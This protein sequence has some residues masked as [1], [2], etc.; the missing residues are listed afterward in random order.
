MPIEIRAWD[1]RN[2]TDDEVA[3]FNKCSNQMRAERLPDDPPTPLEE[4]LQGLK[5]FPDYIQM[6]LWTAWS[7]EETEM[8]AYGLAQYSLEDNLHMA[9]FA[10]SVLPEFRRQ[11]LGMEFLSRIA[12][13]AKEQNRRLLITD[14]TTRVPAGEAFMQRIGAERGLE[15]HTNQLTIADLDRNLVRQWQERAKERATQPA[16]L[17]RSRC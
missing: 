7:P 1:Y 17:R 3:A 12:S 13:V 14:T 16:T 15:T 6:A 2:A 11:G 10:I 9:Q 4:T 5:N 8:V